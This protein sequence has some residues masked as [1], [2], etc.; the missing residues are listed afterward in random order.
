VR[1]RHVMKDQAHR[2]WAYITYLARV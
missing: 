2:A 1:I